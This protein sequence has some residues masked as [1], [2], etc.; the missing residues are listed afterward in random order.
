M[1]MTM[2]I[3]MSRVVLVDIPSVTFSMVVRNPGPSS[4]V[5]V[6][7]ATE[8]FHLEVSTNAAYSRLY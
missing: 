7:A 8:D 2:T 4:S 5:V 1:T 6:E 3:T